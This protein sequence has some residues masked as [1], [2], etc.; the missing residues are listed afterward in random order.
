MEI[1]L[2]NLYIYCEVIQLYLC[3]TEIKVNLFLG[4]CQA[5]CVISSSNVSLVKVC[6]N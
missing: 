3:Y 5:D 4:K 6:I 2:N 1:N